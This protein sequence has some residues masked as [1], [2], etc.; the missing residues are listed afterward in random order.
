MAKLED[1]SGQRFGR[2]TAVCRV[3]LRHLYKGTFWLCHCDCGYDAITTAQRLKSGATQSCGCLHDELLSERYRDG[4]ISSTGFRG[5]YYDAKCGKYIA[6]V[7]H[8]GK[9]YYIGRFLTAEEAHDAYEKKRLKLG[10]PDNVGSGSG[11]RWQEKS[12]RWIVNKRVRYKQYYLGSYKDHAE[13]EAVRLAAD[14]AVK[15]GNFESWYA[16]WRTA[17]KGEK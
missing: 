6:Q 16:E 5:V 2:L 7:A 15:A 12:Q 3:K 10:V 8:K 1:L 4:H 13:A 14:A 17:R 11:V 9:I